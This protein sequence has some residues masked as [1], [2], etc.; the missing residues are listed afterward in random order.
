MRNKVIIVEGAQGVGKGTIT[1]I[2][3]EQMP[4]TNLLRLSGTSDKSEKGLSKV[5]QVR[6]NE[7]D[8][9]L[10]SAGCPINFVLDRSHLSEAVYCNLGYKNYDFEKETD[11]LN[12]KLGLISELYDV[13]LV[14]LTATETEFYTRLKRDKP[15]FL[16][17]E[18]NIQSSIRQQEA[19]ADELM[20]IKRQYPSIKCHLVDTSG[21]DPYDIAYDLMSVVKD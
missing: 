15:K 5:F 19:Y 14:V 17:L 16:D 13:H 4:Y 11:F 21:R 6:K 12:F 1:N 3:R 8:M 7:L 10:S 20:K 2:L 9:I 18:F